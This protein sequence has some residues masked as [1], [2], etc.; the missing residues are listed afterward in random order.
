MSEIINLSRRSFIKRGVGFGGGLLLG[1]YLG[2]TTRLLRVSPSPAAVFAPNAFLR[3]GA[4]DVVTVIVGRSEMGQGVFTSLPMI[5]AEE[6]DANWSNVQVE[7]APVEAVYANP[8]F[9]IQMTGGSSSVSSSWELLRKAGATARAM[10]IS[11]AAANWKVNPAT[12]RTENGQVLH[13]ATGR[14]LSYGKLADKAARLVQPKD[15]VLKDPANFKLIGKP[16]KRLDTPS[17]TNGEAIFGIDVK[18]SGMFT[19]VIARPPVFGAKLKSSNAE[20]AKAMPGVKAVVQTDFGVAVVADGFRSASQARDALEIA[21][22]QTAIAQ[23]DS[24]TLRKQYVEL[25]KKP[26]VITKK[27]GDVDE[28]M[29]RAARKLLAE[30]YVPYLAHAT[31]EPMNCVA[32]VRPDRCEIWT[33]TQFQSRD[34]DAAAQVTGLKPEQVQLNTTLMGGGFGRRGAA[35]NHFVREATQISKAVKAPVKVI[36]TRE[37]D[38]RGGYY[39]PTYYQTLSAGLDNDGNLTAWSH[40]IVGQGVLVGT[41]FESLVDGVDLSSVEGAAETPY[42]F[43]NLTVD[44]HMTKNAVP[45]LWFR[46]VGNIHTA[47]AIES[48]LDEIAHATA[49]DPYQ[50]R[51]SLLG[52]APRLRA[53]LDLAAEKGSWGK[54]L[55]EGQGRGIAAHYSFD[56]YVAQVAEISFSK[57]GKLKLNRI[58]CAIDCGTVVNPDTVRAQMEGGIVFG[59]SAALHGAITLANGRV[60]QSNFHDYPILRMNEMPSIEVYIVPSKEPPTGVGE[61]GVPPVSPAVANAIFAA[62][63]KRIRELPIQTAA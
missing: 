28:A 7:S 18:V 19:T 37:D 26:G 44:Y 57:D 54:Q 50:F 16:T 2:G 46:S 1:F 25:A 22:D 48:F 36:W 39:R 56:S 20:R 10:L 53:V 38:I 42:A 5:I 3:I 35:D 33:G 52:D 27:K 58:V 55:P 41:Q 6:L 63:G 40:R 34:R 51:R 31:M 15:V 9:K 23:V 59:L 14:R 61:P 11:A 24:Q 49:K 4:D 45:V 8:A 60:Q 12:C 13:D 47:F 29:S 32:D 30:Y 17:K 21:W 62:S 43:P